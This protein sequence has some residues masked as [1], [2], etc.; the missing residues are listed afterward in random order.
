MCVYIILFNIVLGGVL[1]CLVFFV[2][3]CEKK[4]GGLCVGI[5]GV[6]KR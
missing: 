6:F 4:G 1:K 2:F 5:L 3:F